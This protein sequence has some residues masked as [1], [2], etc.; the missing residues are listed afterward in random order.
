MGTK[1]VIAIKRENHF[2]CVQCQY[3]GYLS[4]VGRILY[5]HYQDRDTVESIISLG[6]LSSLHER[7]H[8]RE[9][10]P[11]T[12]LNPQEGVTCSYAR[13]GEAD[14]SKEAPKRKRSLELIKKAYPWCS[15]IY[16]YDISDSNWYVAIDE[17]EPVLL[18]EALLKN[19]REEEKL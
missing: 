19:E 13:D 11:H 16:Y 15:Y 8:P 2:A 9:G 4:H 17:N 18:K 5:E 3:D 7:L 10:M 6:N 12:I 14:L 1:S